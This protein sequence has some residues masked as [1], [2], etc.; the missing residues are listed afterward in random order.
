MRD[1]GAGRYKIRTPVSGKDL[2]YV[3]DLFTSTFVDESEYR[4]R[5]YQPA[6]EELPRKEDYNFEIDA[7]RVAN[8]R[9]NHKP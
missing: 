8:G 1:G 3:T 7:N 9:S 4:A 5:G 2:A 6:F